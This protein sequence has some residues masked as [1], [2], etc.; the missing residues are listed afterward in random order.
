MQTV[1][2]LELGL[3]SF[4]NLSVEGWAFFC[5]YG[6]HLSIR[7]GPILLSASAAN[8]QLPWSWCSLG[9][10]WLSA[11][12][13]CLC[14]MSTTLF[15]CGLYTW[16]FRKPYFAFQL[17]QCSTFLWHVYLQRRILYVFADQ[18]LR[19]PQ[20]LSYVKLSFFCRTHRLRN[21]APSNFKA[22]E[23]SSMCNW[24]CSQIL[25]E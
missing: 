11:V 10:G 17:C 6:V 24:I 8:P 13:F 16:S 9:W 2:Q 12:D 21:S 4:W 5:I 22:P 7:L 1:E 19:F 25:R 23:I 20:R 15:V 18:P 14:W 3:R